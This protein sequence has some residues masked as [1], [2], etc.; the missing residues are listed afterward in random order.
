M[1][2]LVWLLN[3]NRLY[4]PVFCF[5]GHV[6]VEWR[7]AFHVVCD[8]AFLVVYIFLERHFIARMAD[9]YCCGRYAHFGWPFR[10]SVREFVG[11]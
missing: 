1:H 8:T 2:P 11:Y 5:W 10:L 9:P 7:W 4:T 6:F 3:F